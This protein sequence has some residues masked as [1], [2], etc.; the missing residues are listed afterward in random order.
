[1]VM[2]ALDI[3]VCMCAFSYGFT[4]YCVKSVA[5]RCSRAHNNTTANNWLCYY[6][7]NRAAVSVEQRLQIEEQTNEFTAAQSARRVGLI[8][9]NCV[10]VCVGARARV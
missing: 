3:R 5:P 10:C 7:Y 1:M 4:R 6:L 9:T 2:V 8:G